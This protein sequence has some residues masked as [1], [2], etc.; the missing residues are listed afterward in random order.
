M[1]GGQTSS[2]RGKKA[3]AKSDRL[4]AL[5]DDVPHRVLRFLDARHSWP[6]SA[7]SPGGGATCGP[8]CPHVS[9]SER[10]WSALLLLRDGA[11]AAALRSLRL[12]SKIFVGLDSR[13]GAAVPHHHRWLRHALG[14]HHDLRALDLDLS[15]GRRFLLPD[16]LFTCASL[17]ELTVSA[18]AHREVIAPKSVVHLPLLR[19]LHLFFVKFGD[20]DASGSAA[21]RLSAGCPAL[22]DVSLSQCSL[23][24][25]RVSFGNVKTLSITDCEYSDIHVD[26]PNTRSLRL[27]VSSKVQLEFMPSLVSAWVYFCGNGPKHLAPCGYALLAA[28]RNV[29][30]LEMLRFNLFLQFKGIMGNNSSSELLLFSELKSLYLREWLVCE[31]YEPFAY[32]LRCAPNLAALTLDERVLH[33]MRRNVVV[34]SSERIM[35]MDHKQPSQKMK[36]ESALCGGLDT[37]RFR[38]SKTDDMEEF[39]RM[40]GLLK[41]TTK[42]TNTVVVWF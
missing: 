15:S 35:P 19:K 33:G 42:P 36:L 17:E 5:P 13:D 26:A 37:L 34:A 6:S 18:I 23:G 38:I 2:R 10:F 40:R 11:A 32:F 7:S 3:A 8:R 41:E 14:R 39:R 25:F 29:Q 27:T 30:H 12:D 22:E 24:S 9:L 31:F 21:E 1:A 28:L 16:A 20:D 4:S